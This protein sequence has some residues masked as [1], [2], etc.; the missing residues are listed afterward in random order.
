MKKML[1]LALLCFS[2]NCFPAGQLLH[3]LPL[4][5]VIANQFSGGKA[6]AFENHVKSLAQARNNPQMY[7]TMLEE[8]KKQGFGNEGEQ[9]VA[10]G[11]YA[12]LQHDDSLIKQINEDILVHKVLNLEREQDALKRKVTTLDRITAAE[13]VA[14]VLVLGGLIL[15]YKKMFDLTYE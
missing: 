10:V 11:K 7:Q 13:S 6:V 12:L 3:L 14:L 2:L 5:N 1:G 4:V 9:L 15:C 8:G